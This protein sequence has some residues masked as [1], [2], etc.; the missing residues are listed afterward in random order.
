[1]TVNYKDITRQ[2]YDST[3]VEYNE[4]TVRLHPKQ[5]AA[6]FLSYLAPN[7]AILD[8]GCGPGRDAKYLAKCG[9][10]VTG[11]DLSP[12]MIELARREVPD[13]NFL[14]M[15]IEKMAF[16]EGQFDA[17]WSSASLL[18]IPKNKLPHVLQRLHHF[19]RTDGV[20]YLSV[21]KGMGEI[22]EADQRYDGVEKFWS[23]FQEEELIEYLK[24][25]GFVILENHLYE[26]SATHQTHPW[27]AIICKKEPTEFSEVP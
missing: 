13:A 1:M 10:Q 5:R 21:K 23:Y 27:I 16:Q 4:N 17:I 7:A 24:D 19:L 25:A 20:L 8:V 22:L 11:F 14:V 26:K 12:H 2:S 18:H 3:A 15:D 6:S 9:F